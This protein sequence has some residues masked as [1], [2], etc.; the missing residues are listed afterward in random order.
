M[1]V[2]Q[3][4]ILGKSILPESSQEGGT[5]QPIAVAAICLS[6]LALVVGAALLAVT[7]KRQRRSSQKKPLVN[8]TAL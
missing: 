3:L 5:V 6:S 7:L 2:K 8:D 1:N 4:H